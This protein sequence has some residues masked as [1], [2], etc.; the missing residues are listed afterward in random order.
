[1]NT[2]P[3]RIIRQSLTTKG[4]IEEKSDHCKFWLYVDEEKTIIHT[5]FSHGQK[6]CGNDLLAKMAHQLKLTR[7]DF[8]DLI[9][10]PLDKEAYIK[11]LKDKGGNYIFDSTGYW[12][13]IFYL[14]L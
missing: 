3:T 13:F 14:S 5:K 2:K 8:N 6:E 11:M 9:D 1:M 7:K 12:S 4:F 10:C